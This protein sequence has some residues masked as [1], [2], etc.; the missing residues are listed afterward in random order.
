MV[1]LQCIAWFDRHD[2][3]CILPTMRRAAGFGEVQASDHA[4]SAAFPAGRIW[5]HLSCNPQRTA[6]HGEINGIIGL[7]RQDE[8]A[9]ITVQRNELKRAERPMSGDDSPMPAAVRMGHYDAGTT[10]R[11]ADETA[12][13]RAP[14]AWPST[15]NPRRQQC[16]EEDS[17][18]M[19]QLP[20]LR[21][22]R[23]RQHACPDEQQ[24]SQ[25]FGKTKEK[26]RPPQR[27]GAQRARE[28][29]RPACGVRRDGRQ[30]CRWCRQNRSCSSPPRRS[31]CHARCSPRSPGRTRD[32]G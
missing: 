11:H 8:P 30:A 5:L 3:R 6:K 28:A 29:L 19:R 31:S 12:T 32:P 1:H 20:P 4:A 26:Q 17:G 22:A 13:G 14:P 2:K 10:L 7:Q 21:M 24:A 27:V 16:D 18:E 23:G 25:R 15:G 9:R